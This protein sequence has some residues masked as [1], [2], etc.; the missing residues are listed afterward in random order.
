MK[1]AEL[2]DYISDAL[3]E[4][5]SF[6]YITFELVNAGWENA[7]IQETFEIIQKSRTA[8]VEHPSPV[9][10]SQ[11]PLV[12]FAGPI[13]NPIPAL[14]KEARPLTLQKRKTQGGIPA[15]RIFTSFLKKEMEGEIVPTDHTATL[16]E[17]PMVEIMSSTPSVVE[18]PLDVPIP[19]QEDKKSTAEESEHTP[20]ESP[21]LRPDGYFIPTLG[22]LADEAVVGKQDVQTLAEQIGKPSFVI[23]TKVN[24]TMW[25]REEPSKA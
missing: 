22:Y 2:V 14:V 24:I 1:S 25:R 10:E 7:D 18:S 6:R 11:K 20:Y 4:G 9:I 13:S 17:V 19:P 16:S 5:K 23:P 12:S 21:A 3:N 8:T 15:S